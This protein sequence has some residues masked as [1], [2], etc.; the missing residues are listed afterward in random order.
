M[1]NIT[2]NLSRPFDKMASRFDVESIE[3]M[4]FR[5]RE[6]NFQSMYKNE[7]IEFLEICKIFE[8]NLSM[9]SLES[10]VGG[11]RR[12]KENFLLSLR[13]LIQ[14]KRQSCHSDYNQIMRDFLYH[15]FIKRTISPYCFVGENIMILDDV[16]NSEYKNVALSVANHM[17]YPELYPLGTGE[18]LVTVI[19][20]MF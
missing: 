1:F 6:M 11:M 8:I 18:T 10:V 14:D 7:I 5:L 16:Q 12:D 20:K 13:T 2:N 19:A 15:E 4:N 9:F 17:C 3:K